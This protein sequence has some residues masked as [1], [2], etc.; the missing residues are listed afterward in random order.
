MWSKE[1]TSGSLF[2]KVFFVSSFLD[3]VFLTTSLT[4]KVFFKSEEF[5][6]TS[7][8]PVETLTNYLLPSLSTSAFKAIKSLSVVNVHVSIPVVLFNFFFSGIIWQV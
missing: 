1:V 4:T 6:F 5:V 8:K 2:C 3:F 7:F